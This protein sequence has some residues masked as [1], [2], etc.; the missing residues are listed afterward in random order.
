MEEKIKDIFSNIKDRISNPLI[1]SY[2]VSWLLY[3]WEIT[4]ALL[5]YDKTQFVAEGC[6]SVFEFIQD[7]LD[8]KWYSTIVPLAFALLYTFG[9]PY[10]K[11][12]VDFF[13][14]KAVFFGKKW[15]AEFLKDELYLKIDNL[16]KKL[17]SIND[18]SVLNGDWRL[19][20]YLE[21]QSSTG[22]VS[23]KI[24]ENQIYISNR[25]YYLVENDSR[26]KIFHITDFYF[27]PI[28]NN[29]LFKLESSGDKENRDLAFFLN[30]DSLCSLN[31]ENGYWNNLTGTQNGKRVEYRKI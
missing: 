30:N 1:F 17:K 23:S 10:I 27:N 26:K 9:M 22:E 5:W 31:L 25:D 8:T 6:R 13:N 3:N 12:L 20:Q 29:M 4:V 7:R 28:N 2:I 24:I 16:E 15:K 14:K 21:E 19:I 11:E 18:T